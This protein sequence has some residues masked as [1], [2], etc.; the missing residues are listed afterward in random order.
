MIHVHLKQT[1]HLQVTGLT[2][3]PISHFYL[4]LE[5]D[6]MS[7]HFADSVNS[8]SRVIASCFQISTQQAA[9]LRDNSADNGF[10]FQVNGKTCHVLSLAKGPDIAFHLFK[11]PD[12]SCQFDL[13][14]NPHIRTIVNGICSY[15]LKPILNEEADIQ[16]GELFHCHCYALYSEEE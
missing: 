8:T 16:N 9:F 12:V 14:I 4:C 5:N 2:P 15:C 1:H 13:I 7:I 11:E 6:D 10:S 3:V